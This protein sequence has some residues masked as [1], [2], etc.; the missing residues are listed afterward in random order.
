MDNG[1]R[2]NVLP[3]V[4]K[5]ILRELTTVYGKHV[6]SDPL[7]NIKAALGYDQVLIDLVSE[8]AMDELSKQHNGTKETYAD[9]NE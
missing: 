3:T 9:G 4:A 6:H 5:Q 1:F 7:K 2:E 8:I